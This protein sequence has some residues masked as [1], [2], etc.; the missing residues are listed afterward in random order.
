[1]FIVFLAKHGGGPRPLVF[2]NHD[3]GSPGP[4]IFGTGATQDYG[5][6]EMI[7][8]QSACVETKDQ[9]Q[10]GPIHLDIESHSVN[11]PV[12]IG[13]NAMRALRVCNMVRVC[14]RLWLLMRLSHH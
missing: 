6:E 12:W 8:N 13:A 14:R 2:T 9:R 11:R 1:M 5:R 7:P 10:G 3:E 4:S